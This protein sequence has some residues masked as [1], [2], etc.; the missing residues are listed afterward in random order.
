MKALPED[1]WNP[2][3]SSVTHFIRESFMHTEFLQSSHSLRNLLLR[4]VMD[5]DGS[6]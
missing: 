5:L 4:S 3:C 6:E 2:A 1:L